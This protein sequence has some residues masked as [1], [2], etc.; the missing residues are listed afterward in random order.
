MEVAQK[1]F[2]IENDVQVGSSCVSG[3]QSG[4]SW[5]NPMLAVL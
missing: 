5:L 3:H 2:E 4:L 1:S